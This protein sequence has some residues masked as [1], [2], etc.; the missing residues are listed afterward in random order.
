MIFSR[1][2][3]VISQH[4]LYVEIIF[5]EIRKFKRFPTIWYKEELSTTYTLRVLFTAKNTLLKF[6]QMKRDSVTSLQSFINIHLARSLRQRIVSFY[7][8][9]NGIFL[10]LYDKC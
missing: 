2:V 7:A 3:S 8:E 6:F 5:L 4:P 1:K 10:I 9:S